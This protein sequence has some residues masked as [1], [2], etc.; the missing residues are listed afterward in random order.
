MAE[1]T[2]SLTLSYIQA[3]LG[4]FAGWGR[5]AAF[6]ETAWTTS[7]QAILDDSTQSGLRRFYYPTSVEGESQPYDWSFMHPSANLDLLPASTNPQTIRLPDDFGGFEGSLN[8]L[9]TASTAQPWLI[10]WTNSPRIRQ[11][12]SVTPSMTG[13]PMY[14]AVEPLRGT[15]ATFGQRFELLIFPIADQEYT[16]Q[17]NYYVNPDYLTGAFPYALGGPEHTETILE[18]CLAVMEERLDDTQGPHAQAFASRLKA[19]IGMDRKKKP[20]KFGPNIDRSDGNRWDRGDVH[21]WAPA[22][23]Y[24]GQPFG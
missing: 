22:A 24:G 9:T 8:V 21:Y 2:L 6:G 7:Q 3:K 19:S 17:A 16:L 14:A 1:P 20:Q 13:P 4:T 18:S 15:G 10:E 12:Y 5:G 23:T 11:M